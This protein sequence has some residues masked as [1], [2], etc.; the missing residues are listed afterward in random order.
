MQGSRGSERSAAAR[1][2]RHCAQG[3]QRWRR[4][5]AGRFPRP[6]ISWAGPAGTVRSL[7]GKRGGTDSHMETQLLGPA[8]L[9]FLPL[10]HPVSMGH[11]WGSPVEMDW[12]WGC[13]LLRHGREHQQD[14]VASLGL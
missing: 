12:G 8:L 13:L 6:L 5:E 4:K 9:Q 1:P 14:S 2:G 7:R 3:A 10:P 11:T